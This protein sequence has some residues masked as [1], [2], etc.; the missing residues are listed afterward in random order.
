MRESQSLFHSPCC[1]CQE[2][3]ELRLSDDPW[4]GR[5]DGYCYDC[6]LAR[7]DA[8]PGECP[9]REPYRSFWRYERRG[10][11]TLARIICFFRGHDVN[12]WQD[13]DTGDWCRGDCRRCWA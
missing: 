10:E 9:N 4:D 1:C 13:P 11:Y 5:L 6:A 12:R 2:P 7:C 8:Y 3:V